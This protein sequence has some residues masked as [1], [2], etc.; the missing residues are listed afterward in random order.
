MRRGRILTMALVLLLAVECS[1]GS[2]PNNR[3]VRLTLSP[4]ARV[5]RWT[6]RPTANRSCSHRIV[7]I[8]TT[9]RTS[10]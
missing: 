9:T 2:G 3:Q 8:P 10:T 6:G 7:T 4:A 1:G 5:G